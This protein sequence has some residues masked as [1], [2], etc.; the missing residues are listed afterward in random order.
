MPSGAISGDSSF[1][2]ASGLLIPVVDTTQPAGS[3]NGKMTL[4][5]LATA[6]NSQ[7]SLAS[8]SNISINSG[9]VAVVA[10]PSFTAVNAGTIETSDAIITG[11]SITGL[12][13]PSATSDAATKSYVDAS[14]QGLQIKPTAALATAA[15]L[16]SNTYSN[17]SA[18]I[19]ATLTGTA[20]SALTVDGVAVTAGALVLV[21]NE[22]T[23]ANNGLYVVTATGSGSAAYV[24][25]RHTDMETSTEF[26]GAFVPVGSG[27]TANSNTLWLANPSGTVTVG[28]TAIP[29]TQ[30]NAATSYVSGTGITISGGTV[31]LSAITNNTVWGNVSGGTATPSQLTPTQLTTLVNTFTSSLSGAAPASGGGTTNYLRADGTWDAPPGT[32]SGAALSG[33]TAATGSNTI[34]NGNNP[35]VWNWALSSATEIGFKFGETT[36]ATS[37]AGSQFIVGIATLSG[38]TAGPLQISAQGTAVLT[39]DQHGALTYAPVSSTTGAGFSVS[40]A[41]GNTSYSVSAGGSFSIT[42]GSSNYVGG[43]ITLTGGVCSSG[44]GGTTGGITIASGTPGSSNTA[45]GSISISTPSGTGSTGSSGSISFTTGNISSAASVGNITF[46]AGNSNWNYGANQGG[47]ISFTTGNGG[48]SGAWSNAGDFT[49]TLG[50]IGSGGGGRNGVFKIASLQT[51]DPSVTGALYVTTSGRLAVSGN[52]PL[53]KLCFMFQG[54]PAA[55]AVYSVVVPYSMTLQANFAGT[56][57]YDSTQATANAVFT[58]NHISGG[59]TTAIGTLTIAPSSHTSVTLSTQAAVTMAAGDVLQLV[60]PSSPDA[61]LA[62][63]AVTMLA[64]RT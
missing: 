25:T 55:S 15:A 64:Y 31:S 1:A 40:L 24:L 35:Q 63:L 4:G 61:T 17:G 56:V 22:T 7:V 38:S 5:A 30:L 37:G 10:S 33:I 28:T 13:T 51:A 53:E 8:G 62:N 54:M 49:V 32:S 2:Y 59:T 58:V 41:A 39:L 3:R 26:S 42:G 60:A 48:P 43:S 16:P 34:A 44:G 45:S 57:V 14:V 20:D 29:F 11:G 47:S 12:P 6:I 36:A 23:G 18:G 46:V 19:G 52:V 9:T 21:K 50:T 27:G